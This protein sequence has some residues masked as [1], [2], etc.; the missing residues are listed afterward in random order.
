MEGRLV[1]L[2]KPQSA[3]MTELHYLCTIAMWL[4]RYFSYVAMNFLGCSGCLHDG[5]CMEHDYVFAKLFRVEFSTL[6]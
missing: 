1:S 5:K 4:L 2:A 3:L 6:L